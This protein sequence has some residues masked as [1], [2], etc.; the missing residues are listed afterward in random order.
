MV[1]TCSW[2]GVVCNTATLRVT[3]ITLAPPYTYSPQI[4]A[5]LDGWPELLSLQSIQ[6]QRNQLRGTLPAAWASL[7]ML[8]Y[9]DVSANTLG[10]TLPSSWGIHGVG[11]KHVNLSNNN[12]QVNMVMPYICTFPVPIMIGTETQRA[13]Q[14]FGFQ[15]CTQSTTNPSPHP[16]QSGLPKE[17]V[18][19]A[20]GRGWAVAELSC[21]YCNLTGPL[22]SN[23]SLPSL[24]Y[25]DLSHNPATGRF[26]QVVDGSPALQGLQLSYTQLSDSL[27][28]DWPFAQRQLVVADLSYNPGINGTVPEGAG[29][30]VAH[31]P[32]TMWRPF[33]G[34]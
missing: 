4:S 34:V 21:S 14:L 1:P 29:T 19:P 7:P 11:M 28:S 17:W 10:G 6:M 9:V 20:Y 16:L 27:G 23:W 13:D 3:G 2:Q 5:P 33:F 24:N 12:F 32:S 18:D 15:S 8:S 25:P 26:K 31:L 30:G 22:P